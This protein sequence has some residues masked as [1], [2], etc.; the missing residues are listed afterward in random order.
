MKIRDILRTKGSEVITVGPDQPVIAAVQILAEHRIGAL[1]VTAGEE[2]R[3]IISERDVLNLVAGSPEA[4]G[5]TPV[6]DI[7][8]SDLIVGV[9]DDDLD[10]V[11]NSMTNNRVRHLP[12]VDHGRLVGI[13][14]IGDVVNEVRRSV[15]S[16]NRHLKDYIHGVAR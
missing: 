11:M 1:V 10:Y 13:V 16:E 6:Q 5:A 2:I 9:E 12:I 14:S 3:G 8:T 15:E 7:M 4:V